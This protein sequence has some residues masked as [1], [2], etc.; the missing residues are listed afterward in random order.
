MKKGPNFKKAI[1]V[2]QSLIREHDLEPPIDVELLAEELGLDVS[3]EHLPDDASG[4]LYVDD[5][6]GMIGVHSLHSDARQRFTIAHEIGHFLLH[7]FDT[8]HVDKRFIM[9]DAK[10]STAEDDREIEANWFAA[11]LLM[12]NQWIREDV[13]E[14]GGIDLENDEEIEELADKYEVSNAAMQYRLIRFVRESSW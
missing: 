8:V 9:R 12:P 1:R 2:A 3:Y 6:F 11:E 14:L 5:D 4:F 7:D 10:S 13:E